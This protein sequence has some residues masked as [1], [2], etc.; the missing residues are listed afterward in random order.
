MTSTTGEMFD[1]ET[2]PSPPLP[3]SI[4][5]RSHL[6]Q[7]LVDSGWTIARLELQILKVPLDRYIR[8]G[9]TI[10]AAYMAWRK[11]VEVASP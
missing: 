7:V 5:S 1:P 10:Q 3:D 2:E 8:E 4:H 9:K 6:Q 11:H